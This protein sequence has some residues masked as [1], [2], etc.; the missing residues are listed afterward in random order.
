VRL[1]PGRPSDLDF[2]RELQAVSMRP[3]VERVYGRWD[4]EEQRARFDAST[5]PT[6]HEIVE[7]GGEPVGCRL[8][9][10]HPD[11]LELVRLYLLPAFQ[12][13]GLGTR[14]VEELAREADASG[15]PV[16]LRVLRG[17]PAERLYRRLGFEATGRTAAHQS[18]ERRTLVRSP[19]APPEGEP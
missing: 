5:D 7:L 10:R 12:N 18:M 1:R 8:V 15:L 3:H 9:R 19:G 11:A 4:P 6:A 13:R 17:N 16:R 2:L 14:L